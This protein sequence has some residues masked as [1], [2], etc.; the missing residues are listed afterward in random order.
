MTDIREVTYRLIGW[1]FMDGLLFMFWVVPLVSLCVAGLGA[2]LMAN[3]LLFLKHRW[4]GTP[5]DEEIKWPWTT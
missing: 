1:W 5:L 3:L 4:A 2:F